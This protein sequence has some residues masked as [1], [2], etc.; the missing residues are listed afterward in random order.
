MKQYSIK[1]N[2]KGRQYAADVTE[3][4]G[5]DN[6][7]YAIS[8]RDEELTRNF[9]SNV[10]RKDKPDG[11]W[12]YDFPNRPDGDIYMDSLLNALQSFLSNS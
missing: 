11:E 7:Q 4:D 12:H 5:L 8:P 6:T 9:K 2:F 10:I 1:F 3:I